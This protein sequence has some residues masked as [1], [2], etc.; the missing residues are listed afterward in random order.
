MATITVG[1]GQQYSTIAAGV[2]AASSGDTVDVE[3]G[4]YANDFTTISQNITLQAVGGTVTMTATQEPPDGKAIIDEGGSGVDVTIQ[5]FDISG[6]QASDGNGAAIRYEGGNLTL[7]DDTIH[8]NQDGLL[9]GADPNGNITINDSTFMANGSGSGTTHDIYVGDINSLTVQNSTITEADVG[10]EIKS[11][12]ENNTITG[13]TIADGPTG[14]SSY[15]ID[16]PNGGNATITGNVIEKGANAQNPTAISYGEEGSVYSSSSLNVSDNVMLN[17]DPS[18]DTTG[19]QND[20]SVTASVTNNQVYGWNTLVSGPSSVSGNTTLTTEPSLSSLMPS[21]STTGTDAASTTASTDASTSATSGTTD[22]STSDTGGTTATTTAD[23]SGTTATST[24]VGS[25]P[26]TM[27]TVGSSTSTPTFTSGDTS[28]ASQ[29]SSSGTVGAASTS[30]PTTSGDLSASA[31]TQA[32]TPAPTVGTT[33]TP[34]Y[35]TSSSNSLPGWHDTSG[36][37]GSALHSI[38]VSSGNGT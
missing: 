27:N 10:H 3:A 8:N 19:V 38:T 24:D 28:G 17:D 30:T 18:S 34:D 14:T 23:T 13:N 1:P 12:A 25:A 37:N 22:T 32:Q 6:A 5:G 21:S 15:E 11:R 9:S 26:I 16:L 7:N 33:S 20:T 2:A 35:S 31:V 29:T 36:Y 4:T